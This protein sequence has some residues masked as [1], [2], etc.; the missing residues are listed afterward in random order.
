M[1]T[2]RRQGEDSVNRKEFWWER[3]WRHRGNFSLPQR[4]IVL[5]PYSEFKEFQPIVDNEDWTPRAALIDPHWSL[6]QIIAS[7]AGFC[8]GDVDIL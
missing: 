2:W 4:V 3:E 1:G 5:C 7:L 8:S 6:E